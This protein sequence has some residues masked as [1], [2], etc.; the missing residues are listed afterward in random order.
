MSEKALNR[1]SKRAAGED[2]EDSEDEFERREQEWDLKNKQDELESSQKV[3]MS[4]LERFDTIL[5]DINLELS[6]FLDEMGENQD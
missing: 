5:D 1:M 3:L 6:E 4:K 2:E